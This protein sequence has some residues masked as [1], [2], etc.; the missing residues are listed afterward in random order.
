M[1]RALQDAAHSTAPRGPIEEQIGTGIAVQAASNHSEAATTMQPSIQYNSLRRSLSLPALRGTASADHDIDDLP[2]NLPGQDVGFE[3]WLEG[4]TSDRVSSGSKQA[5]RALDRRQ[6]GTDTDGERPAKR[7][8]L[9]PQLCAPSILSTPPDD[10]GAAPDNACQS[11][12]RSLCRR[13]QK[14]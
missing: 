13:Q 2:E 5:K 10:M 9:R 7:Q 3:R 6:D 11:T 14:R 1:H 12:L 4:C 8:M